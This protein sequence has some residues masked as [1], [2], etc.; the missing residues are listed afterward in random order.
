MNAK[1]LLMFGILFGGLLSV[2]TFAE[3]PMQNTQAI[4]AKQLANELK[5]LSR[6]PVQKELDQ[7]INELASLGD[8][9][10]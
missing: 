7:T 2:K 6:K 1:K 9:A 3:Q 4:K 5:V 8:A 10:T